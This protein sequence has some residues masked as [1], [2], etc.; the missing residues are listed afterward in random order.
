MS[1]PMHANDA[2]TFNAP[3]N[4]FGATVDA[5][6]LAS[7]A[8]L[9]FGSQDSLPD[10]SSQDFRD[11][12]EMQGPVPM[13][14]ASRDRVAEVLGLIDEHARHVI[15]EGVYLKIADALQKWHDEA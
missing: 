12:L 15:P 3:A 4:M 11:I 1:Q 9:A 14:S 5:S 2:A 10:F 7:P 8:G 6:G 13:Q